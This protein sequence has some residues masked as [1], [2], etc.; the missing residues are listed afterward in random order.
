MF[1]VKL[2]SF[3]NRGLSASMPR[4]SVIALKSAMRLGK[5]KML[6]P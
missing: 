2:G 3:E 5:E 6:A 4:A 1:N